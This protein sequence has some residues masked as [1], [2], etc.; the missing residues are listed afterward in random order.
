MAQDQ[1]QSPT[2]QERS[3]SSKYAVWGLFVLLILLLLAVIPRGP[4]G[5]EVSFSEYLGYLRDSSIES[6]ERNN[7][8]GEITFER[9]DDSG[10]VFVLF[11]PLV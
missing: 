1:K 3:G 8:T 4:A 5:T 10:E 7:N 9:L 2:G 6:V 11:Q